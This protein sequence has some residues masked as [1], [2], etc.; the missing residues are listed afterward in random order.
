MASD[1]KSYRDIWLSHTHTHTVERCL[2]PWKLHLTANL[3]SSHPDLFPPHDLLLCSSNATSS[4]STI[5]IF[6]LCSPVPP[7]P[8]P[9]LSH[10]SPSLFSYNSDFTL[11]LLHNKYLFHSFKWNRNTIIAKD[12]L[13]PNVFVI[14]STF[15]DFR[16][17]DLLVNYLLMQWEPSFIL[18]YA[19][20][21]K[22][23]QNVS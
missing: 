9:L 18:F 16:L 3:L 19:R 21:F 13:L 11:N 6:L 2:K 22:L 7:P 23:P 1:E 15:T 10:R 20:C 4:S 14:D 17:L 5:F 12:V 8:K